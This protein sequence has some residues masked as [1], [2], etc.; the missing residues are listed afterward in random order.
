MTDQQ[1]ELRKCWRRYH[2]ASAARFAAWAER[3]YQRPPP[4]HVPYPEG[5]QGLTCGAKT[6]AGTPC[7]RRDLY[8]SG[9]CCLHGGLSTGPKRLKPEP[10]P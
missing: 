6:R 5:L 9:R 10:T 2:E 4:A 7:K 8:L 1:T 3:D